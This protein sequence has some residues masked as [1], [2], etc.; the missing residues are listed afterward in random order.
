MFAVGKRVERGGWVER[1]GG[2]GREEWEDVW[3]RF[4]SF[5]FIVKSCMVAAR[6][7]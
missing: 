4:N 5:F 1:R 7:N 6:R 3:R 2:E